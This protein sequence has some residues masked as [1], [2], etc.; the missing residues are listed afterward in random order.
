MGDKTTAVLDPRAEE[1]RL[2][3]LVSDI[4]DEARRQ[5]ADSC[6]V[7]V[8]LDAGLSV[9]VRMGDVETVEFNRDQG[10]G[11]TVYQGKK[12]GSA[13]TSDS[14]PEAIRETVK[15]ACDIAGYGS[16]DPC[17]GLADAELMAKDLPDLDLYHPWGI[18]AEQ[19][20]EL[21]LKCED[22]GR[23]FNNKITNSDGAN[24]STH[25]GCRVYGNSH[26]FIGSYISSRHSLSCVLIA[27]QADDMQRDY[28][29]TYARNGNDLESA[30]DVGLKAAERTVARLGGQKVA[31]GQVPVLFAP[32][33]ASGLL[34]HFLGAISGGS[35]YRQAS[36]LLDHLGKPVFPDWVRIHE[37]PLLKKGQGSASFDNDG[38]ATRAK[39]FITDGVLSNYLLSTYSARK[40]GMASTANAGGVNNLFLD[41]NAGGQEELLKQMGTGLL[42]TELM[43]QGVNTVTGDYS[44]GAGGFWVENGV[45]QY[46]VSEVTIAGNLKDMYMNIV[47][48]GNDYDRRGNVQTGSILISEMTLAGE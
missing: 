22:A 35:L 33:V 34:S 27:Q 17:A 47:A 36:F 26:G 44:R 3:T 7:G 42:V 14:S 8:S 28:W 11:I 24:V 43:G 40:L 23:S 5:G 32:E 46:P 16:E 37:Q 19:A 6:E 4:L 25:Q 13:S 29:Y 18:D 21:A 9:G 39:D 45:I 41:S 30:S 38:L 2:K 10:F 12:K 1:D 20:I 31:T 15:A 48:A